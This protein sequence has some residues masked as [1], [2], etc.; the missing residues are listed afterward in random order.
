MQKALR[1]LPSVDRLLHTDHCQTLSKKFGQAAMTDAL[2]SVLA[3]AR[4]RIQSGDSFSFNQQSLLIE[5]E[6]WLV[7]HFAPSL[8]AVINATGVILHTN[9]GRAPLSRQAIQA[10]H[11]VAQGYS[12]LEYELD[13][14]KRGSRYTHAV[15]KLKQLSGAEDA[16]IVNNNAS[17]LVLLLSA[18]ARDREVIISRGQ[19]VEIGGGFRIPEIMS[20]SGALLREVGS[21]NRT[22]LT[23][24]ENAITENTVMLLRVHPSNFRQAGFVEATE[25]TDLVALAKKRELMVADDVG[26]G[27][28]LETSGFG[29]PSEP[30]VQDGVSTGADV[31]LFSGDKLLGGP[32][33]GILVGKVAVIRTL[34]MHPLAR[35][36][37]ADKLALAALGAT[38]DSYLRDRAIQEIPIWWMIARKIDELREIAERWQKA[39]GGEV[40]ES[41]SAI[42]GGSIPGGTLPTVAIQ[43]NVNNP[44]LF[45]QQLRLLKIPIIARI[46]KD[47]VILDPRTVLPEQEN[48]FLSGIQSVRLQLD[49]TKC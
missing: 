44:D 9:L 31:V 7:N 12:T 8:R 24:Y 23:D 41:S 4:M 35:A 46:E 11:S 30:T 15:E 22:R 29:L 42:G 26:S 5:A 40:I 38:L 43:L 32:Q 21:T 6:K 13:S 10:M 19:L 25:L 17:A 48:D 37:R 33:A 49:C 27:A 18:L 39:V 36:M 2:R 45:S 20:E 1:A 28:L 14:G 16:L 47:A 3:N 34:K